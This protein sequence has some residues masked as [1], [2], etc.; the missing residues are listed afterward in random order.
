MQMIDILLKYILW[1]E[2]LNDL[3]AQSDFHK[4]FVKK[5]GQVEPFLSQ[6]CSKHKKQL[7]GLEF[8]SILDVFCRQLQTCAEVIY[9]LAHWNRSTLPRHWY[10]LIDLS[11]KGTAERW[12]LLS[13]QHST[14]RAPW[15]RTK[16]CLPKVENVSTWL[17][18][19]DNLLKN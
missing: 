15:L 1:Y 11:R 4:N 17:R 5:T 16:D 9:S 3:D 7:S 8:E 13:K 6:V 18:T 19:K 12:L 2:F 14:K 10:L